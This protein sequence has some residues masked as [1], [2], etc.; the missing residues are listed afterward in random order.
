MI[1]RRRPPRNNAEV[2]LGVESAF[3]NADE[4]RLAKPGDNRSRRNLLARALTWLRP[5]RRAS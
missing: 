4:P 5:A 1:G 3:M 2:P